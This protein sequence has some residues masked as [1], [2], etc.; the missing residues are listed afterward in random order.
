MF[1]EGWASHFWSFAELQKAGQFR[2]YWDK[3][4][5]AHYE[6]K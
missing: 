4:M 2:F 3:L 1:T 5:T 6:R